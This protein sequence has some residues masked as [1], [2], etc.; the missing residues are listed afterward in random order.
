VW[1]PYMRAPG[2]AVSL[3]VAVRGDGQVRQAVVADLRAPPD[4]HRMY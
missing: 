2:N 3:N 1:H 4:M